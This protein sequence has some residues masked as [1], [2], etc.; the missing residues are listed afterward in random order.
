MTAEEQEITSDQEN[1]ERAEVRAETRHPERTSS[2]IDN[3]VFVG[4][5]HLMNY[6]NSIE[7]Q[8]KN[9]PEVIIKARGKFISKAV[10]IVEVAKR[11]GL[12]DG[13]IKIKEIKIGT[14]EYNN[15]GKKINVSTIDIMLWR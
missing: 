6:V 12:T 5:K 9:S 13:N 1:T 7:M 3:V 2:E 8:F 15:E 14:E 10:D 11:R 4:S